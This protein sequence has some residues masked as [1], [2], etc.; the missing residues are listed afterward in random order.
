MKMAVGPGGIEGL[1]CLQR[2]APSEVESPHSDT[3]IAF[4][5]VLLRRRQ[6]RDLFSGRTRRF[7]RYSILIADLDDLADL[8]RQKNNK[9]VGSIAVGVPILSMAAIVAT[10]AASA[11]HSWGGSTAEITTLQERY[12]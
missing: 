12:E 9:Y 11:V 6:R 7:S 3:L 10:L 2:P 4:N 1:A 5:V 8:G